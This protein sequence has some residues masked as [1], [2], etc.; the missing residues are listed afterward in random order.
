MKALPAYVKS[1]EEQRRALD[2][3]IQK[4]TAP[5]HQFSVR[6]VLELSQ[7]YAEWGKYL[8]WLEQQG[9]PL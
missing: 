2:E 9:A 8:D 5:D 6:D 3:Y 7:L 4:T 1:P